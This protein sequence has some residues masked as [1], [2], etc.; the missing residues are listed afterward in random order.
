MGSEQDGY[1]LLA[2]YFDVFNEEVRQFFDPYASNDGSMKGSRV[3]TESKVR[4]LQDNTREHEREDNDSD[5]EFDDMPDSDDESNYETAEEYEEEI[6][7]NDEIEPLGTF[8]SSSEKT[9]FFHCLSRYSIHRL[10]EWR[11]RLPAKSSFEIM[12]YYRVLR[13]NLDSLKNSDMKRFGGIL[14]R[15]D[16]PIAY[17]MDEFFVEFE[18]RMSAGIRIETDKQLT[19]EEDDLQLICV[20]NWER[21]WLPIYSRSAIEELSPMCK[22]PL[23]FSHEALSFLTKCCEDYT[24]K[25]LTSALLN[26]LEKVSVPAAMFRQ[27]GDE[28]VDPP[29][30]DLVITQDKSKDIF[31]HVVNKESIA[32]AVKLLKQEGLST[33]TL[34]E[35][36]LRTLEKFQLKH[37]ETG[38][39]FKNKHVTM[40]LVPSLLSNF[41]ISNIT[42]HCDQAD[43]NRDF[44]PDLTIARKLYKLN[45]GP[46]PRKKRRLVEGQR[47]LE[48]DPLDRMDNPLEF[49][50]CDWETQLIDDVDARRSR[51][52]QHTLL[53]YYSRETTPLDLAE[54]STDPANAPSC[55]VPQLTSS[56]VSRYLHSNT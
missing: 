30:D 33:P 16:L 36:V 6:N 37:Q 31:P 9:M 38:K 48:D 55:P 1:D 54:P 18:E 13:D 28:D 45:G 11:D 56:M 43:S 27:D 17:E 5:I 19:E 22:E 39:L 15:V 44:Q 2:D 20:K 25:V 41:P 46:P 4:W 29:S 53:A 26:D 3:H 32:N 12:V 51:V 49:D 24:K 50:L 42:T 34:G 7:K 35:T 52:Y 8:W 47:F 23:P 14:S 10:A 21:R 40:S